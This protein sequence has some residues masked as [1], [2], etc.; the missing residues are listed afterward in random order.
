MA[1]QARSKKKQKWLPGESMTTMDHY[2]IQRWAEERGG[3]PALNPGLGL[4][5]GI[6]HIDFC[7]YPDESAFLKEITW[8]EF[9]VRFEESKLVFLY[10]EE[11]TEGKQSRFN[12][13]VSRR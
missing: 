5:A 8:R 7:E 11:T 4:E 1:M 3:K 10:Q 12:K 6:L 13:L 2:V 9:F